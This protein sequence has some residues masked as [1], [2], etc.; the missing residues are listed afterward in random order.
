MKT[1][2]TITGVLLL[3]IAFGLGSG[4]ILSISHPDVPMD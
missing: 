2:Q 3:A 1:V 4:L